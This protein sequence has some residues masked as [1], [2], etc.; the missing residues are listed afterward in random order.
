MAVSGCG[1]LGDGRGEVGRQFAQPPSPAFP[2]AVREGQ[3]SGLRTGRWPA[4]TQW[5]FLQRGTSCA[6]AFSTRLPVPS[7]GPLTRGHKGSTSGHQDGR[8]LRLIGN[9]ASY[10]FFTFQGE[11]APDDGRRP[12]VLYSGVLF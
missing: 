5:G 9:C 8:G 12:S 11:K 2:T 10:F 6:L 3:G 7:S 1:G 4:G